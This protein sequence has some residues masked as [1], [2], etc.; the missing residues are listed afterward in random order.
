MKL[1]IIKELDETIA[2]IKLKDNTA[3][4]GQNTVDQFE[5]YL[6]FVLEIVRFEII[7]FGLISDET[8]K[9]ASVLFT[10]QV[11]EYYH[12]DYPALYEKCS[13]LAH[14]L[15]SYNRK[16][17]NH[18]LSGPGLTKS[19]WLSFFQTSITKLAQKKGLFDN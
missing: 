10:F 19:T 5:F 18:D 1:Q 16:W 2:S 8:A 11:F 4:F 17:E 12:R 13:N 6:V 14:E 3:E 9:A 15:R 7:D